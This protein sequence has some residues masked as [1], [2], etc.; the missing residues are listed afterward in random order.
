M[1]KLFGILALFTLTSASIAAAQAESSPTEVQQETACE[2]YVYPD[3]ARAQSEPI[4]IRARLSADI[5]EV[6]QVEIE[7]ASGLAIGRVETTE[8]DSIVVSL[9]TSG[10]IAGSWTLFFKGDQGIC[11]ASWIVEEASANGR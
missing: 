2:A 8:S 9:D 4:E 1:K 11:T 5:G 3:S 6:T 7:E 10:A